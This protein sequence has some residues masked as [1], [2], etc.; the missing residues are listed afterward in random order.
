MPRVYPIQAGAL[1]SSIPKA[2]RVVSCSEC[3]RRKQRCDRES[4]CNQCVIRKVEYLCH[5]ENNY[6]RIRPYYHSSHSSIANYSVAMA[7][8]PQ[9]ISHN[10]VPMSS[11][12]S[13][14]SQ[15][16][17]YQQHIASLYNLSSD[18]VSPFY[19]AATAGIPTQQSVPSRGPCS[20]F[21]TTDAAAQILAF[22]RH[23]TQPPT[24]SEQSRQSLLSYSSGAASDPSIV[25]P[26]SEGEDGDYESTS[27][28]SDDDGDDPVALVEILGYFPTAPSSVAHDLREIT[29][30]I[31]ELPSTVASDDSP[32][33]SDPRPSEL[34]R[35]KWPAVSRLLRTMPARPYADL[36]IRIFY[37]EANFYHVLNELKFLEDVNAW[38]ALDERRSWAAVETAC[39]MFRVFSI[40]LYFIP[41]ENIET[42]KHIDGSVTNLA[43]DYHAVAV[44]LA[45]LLPDS[46]GKVIERV[47]Q[48]AWYKYD[49]RMKDSWYCIGQAIRMAQEIN[50][51]VEAPN[52]APSFERENRR[53]IWWLTYYWDRCM[54]IVHSRPFM[55]TD[56]VCNIPMPLDLPDDCCYPT[57]RP[58]PQLTPYTMRL[59]CFHLYK[60]I[61]SIYADPQGVLVNLMSFIAMLPPYLRPEN[62]DMSLDEEY[63]FLASHRSLLAAT[64]YMVGCAI[65]RR[66]VNIPGLDFCLRLLRVCADQLKTLKKHQYRLF[67]LVYWNLE[68][69]VLICR[70]II[71]ETRRQG[72][73]V[74]RR[75]MKFSDYE[76]V[77]ET[78]GDDAG[79]GRLKAW[80][81]LEIAEDAVARLRVFGRNSKLA[82]NASKLLK[83]IVAKARREL[84]ALEDLRLIVDSAGYGSPGSRNEATGISEDSITGQYYSEQQHQDQRDNGE[85]QNGETLRTFNTRSHA[86]R[87]DG[88][89]R[90]S[91]QSLP[92]AIENSGQ[93][94]YNAAAIVPPPTPATTTY[95]GQAGVGEPD[96]FL[97][98]FQVPDESRHDLSSLLN[99]GSL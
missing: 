96:F 13:A 83:Q 9:P 91:L 95:L 40:A 28:T 66:D 64:I 67:M 8:L 27:R 12:Q 73:L 38:W 94:Y 30:G 70:D 21:G 51:H 39:L 56:D 2:T 53:R 88:G 71:R 10:S 34:P 33:K 17:P 74:Q 72:D 16:L 87:I 49:L 59:T 79:Q 37:Q 57:V 3:H 4:P 42:I 76:D 86:P 98:I 55:I 61:S 29:V 43:K 48:A 78:L 80:T 5:Y 36:L 6:R 63:P 52:E 81:Y 62:P 54:A 97:D 75:A 45:D 15:L 65:Y 20:V 77:S 90:N 32:A 31:A 35:N 26:P 7:Q 99:S 41:S 50:L 11:F 23:N 24:T 82:W 93:S 60:L 58:G 1:E 19:P 84:K 14:D 69:S 47:L 68:P 22:A 25:S 44:E 46:C 89:V 18:S 85:S 92:Y